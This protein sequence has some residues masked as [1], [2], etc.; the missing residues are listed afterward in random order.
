MSSGPVIKRVVRAFSKFINFGADPIDST[1]RDVEDLSEL[2]QK[3]VRL[4]P[5]SKRNRFIQQCVTY[6]A[7]EKEAKKVVESIQEIKY[8]SLPKTY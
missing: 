7:V 5:R 4:L 6:R 1:S 8:Y 2:D 3:I